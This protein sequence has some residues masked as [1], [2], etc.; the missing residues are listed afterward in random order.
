MMTVSL[1]VEPY[2]AHYMYA[3]YA[4]CVHEGAI[5]LS[6]QSDLYHQLLGWTLP[7]PKGVSWKEEGNLTL[8]LP[9]PRIGKD[10]RTYNYLSEEARYRITRA[11]KEQMRWEMMDYMKQERLKHGVM[12]TRSMQQ[13]IKDFD[14]E[15]LVNEETL[16]KYFQTRRKKERV[17]RINRC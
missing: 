6:F 5:K 7:R 14:M 2:L 10:P 17:D 13:F 9:S 16:M 15:D 4:N 1:N 12:F 3:R 11:I 8:A